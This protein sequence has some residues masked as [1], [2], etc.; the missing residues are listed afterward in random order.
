MTYSSLTNKYIPA[1]TSNYSRGRSG[2]KVIKITPHHMAGN[3]SIE[4]CGKLWQNA[5]RRASSNYGIGTDGRIGCYVQEEDR[6]WC[7][8]SAANDNVA[9]TIEV[10]NDGGANTNWHVSDKAINSLIN[11]MVDICKRYG[12]K[13]MNFTGNANGNLTLHKYFTSTACPGPY[14]EGKMPWIASQVN[15]KLTSGDSSKPKL[16]W[17][18][19]D[20]PATYI[21]NK[22]PTNLWNFDSITWSGCKSV[23]T[24][25][26]GDRVDIYG[27][28]LNESLNAVYLLTEYSFTKK[29][30]NGFNKVDLDKI[31]QPAPAPTPTPE[32]TPEPEPEPTPEPEPE[33]TPEDPTVGILEKIIAFIMHIIELITKKQ[34]E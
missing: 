18:K 5:S 13:K 30:T 34:G 3:L 11:L 10:A 20:K 2:K 4:G 33:P 17:T 9:I 28:V 19:F 31:V 21:C 29:I 32:P 27:S 25:N 22:Q 14:L 7:S 16:V 23:K 26:K 8:S 24:F 1:N 15:K 12:I 6:S